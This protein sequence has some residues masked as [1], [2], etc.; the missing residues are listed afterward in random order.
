[1]G[2]HFIQHAIYMLPRIGHYATLDVVKEVPFGV[3]LDGGP[4]GEILLP[5]R[6]VPENTQIDDELEVFIYCDSEGRIIASTLKPAA[7]ANQFAYLEVVD[8]SKYGAFMEFPF[9]LGGT[10]CAHPN[11]SK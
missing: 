8:T 1:M 10:H 6:Y 5:K 2:F 11:Y 4:F 3:Y 7:T 9:R